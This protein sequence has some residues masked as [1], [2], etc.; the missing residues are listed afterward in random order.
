MYDMA[1]NKS[2]RVKRE[3][4]LWGGNIACVNEFPSGGIHS[5]ISVGT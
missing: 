1:V 3:R 5:H 4:M 2:S